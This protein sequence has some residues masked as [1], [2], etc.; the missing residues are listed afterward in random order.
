MVF[1]GKRCGASSYGGLQAKG[2]ILLETM[3][4]SFQTVVH[5]RIEHE[6][7]SPVLPKEWGDGLSSGLLFRFVMN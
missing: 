3:Q 4:G 2:P 7:V 5:P 1:C 6:R